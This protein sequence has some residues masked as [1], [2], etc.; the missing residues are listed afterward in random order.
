MS[1]NGVN[2]CAVH[3]VEM[4][5]ELLGLL[6][7]ARCLRKLGSNYIE[8]LDKRN[9]DGPGIDSSRNRGLKLKDLCRYLAQEV[10]KTGW[11]VDVDIF[12]KKN[13][14][15]GKGRGSGAIVD[16]ALKGKLE[17]GVYLVHAYKP[18]GRG[19]CVVMRYVRDELVIRDE[20]KTSGMMNHRW[21]SNIR[22]IREICVRQVHQ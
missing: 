18:S 21:I 5:L 15:Q 2:H 10:P 16:L 8:W 9:T 11:A 1:D 17:P 6:K 19:H 14:F 7:E 12:S 3:S 13:Y 20:S 22:F 4:V